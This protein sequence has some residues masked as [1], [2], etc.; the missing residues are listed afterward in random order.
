MSTH[1]GESK[2][3]VSASNWGDYYVIFNFYNTQLFV[4]MGYFYYYILKKKFNSH[5][6]S[7]SKCLHKRYLC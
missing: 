7:A 1:I 6:N 2:C 4:S 3:I 5:K